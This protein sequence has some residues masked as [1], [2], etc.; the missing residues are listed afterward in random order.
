MKVDWTPEMDAELQKLYGQKSNGEIAAKLGLTVVQVKYRAYVTGLL[1]RQ[2]GPSLEQVIERIKSL[3]AAG[4]TNI[5]IAATFEHGVG[6]ELIG[7]QRKRL[8]LIAP[9]NAKRQFWKR[10]KR[11]LGWPEKLSIRAVQVLETFWRLKVPLTREQICILVGVSTRGHNPR[12]K[13]SKGVKG[14]TVLGELAGAG[15]ISRIEGAIRRQSLYFLNAG[16]LPDDCRTEPFEYQISGVDIGEAGVLVPL[17]GRLDFLATKASQCSGE[18][19]NARGHDHN[20]SEA[21]REGQAR[22]RKSGQ[23]PRFANRQRRTRRL[24]ASN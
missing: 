7:F 22:R 1:I 23:V 2:N 8:G 10:W 21:S 9:L 18:R 4:K 15:Y 13:S 24:A 6:H 20:S 3:H 5:E 14:G 16:V 17:P 19:D 12:S 11:N